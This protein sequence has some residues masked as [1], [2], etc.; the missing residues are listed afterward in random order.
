MASDWNEDYLDLVD[1][2]NRE[3]VEYVVVGAFA[4]AQHGL[5]RATGDIDFFV[6]ASAENA[7]RVIRALAAFGAPL[8]AAG[9]EA[10]STSRHPAP[11][12][13]SGSP[14]GGSTS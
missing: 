14:H 6:R 13:S 1:S 9:V 3:G 8:E 7:G 2:L 5:P 12:T 10:R 11:S 4:L